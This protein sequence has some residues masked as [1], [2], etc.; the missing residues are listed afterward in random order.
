MS[1]LR[2]TLRGTPP[3]SVDCSPLAPDLLAGK[4][5]KDIEAIE[6]QCGNRRLRVGELFAV[7]GDDPNTVAFRGGSARL[8]RIG[9]GMKSGSV[10]VEGECGDYLG[11]GM[12]GGA[13]SIAGDA[14]AFAGSGMRAGRIEIRG[15]AGD[16][17]GAALPGD[18]QGMRGGAIVVH[19]SAGDRAGD[20]MRRG[21]ILIKGNAGSYCGAR[22]LAGTILVAGE[23]GYAPGYGLKRGTLL[24]ERAPRELLPTFR[25]SGVHSLLFLALL[26]KE[27]LREG[28][29]FTAFLPLAGRVRRFCGD[30]ATGGAG[31]ILVRV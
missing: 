11:F 8:L 5:R 18:R 22:V 25:D 14:G 21:L 19:G 15:N 23:A 6:L 7:E 4:S 17:L 30:L 12:R 28:G 9:A 2:L 31:E 1:G 24:L 16:F 10:T 29:P 27:M 26:E 13:I 3:G 20:R